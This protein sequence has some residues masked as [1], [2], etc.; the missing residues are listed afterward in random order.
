MQ[1]LSAIPQRNPEHERVKG[2]QAIT[3]YGAPRFQ[4]VPAPGFLFE[5][6]H[7]S[8]DALRGMFRAKAALNTTAWVLLFESKPRRSL[9]YES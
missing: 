1:N 5:L 4:I 2:G 6:K 9:L 8:E 7:C 3:F